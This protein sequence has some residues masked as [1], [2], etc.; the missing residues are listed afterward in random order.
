M[1]RVQLNESE[2]PDF[3]VIHFFRASSGE[4]RCR[5]INAQSRDSWIARDAADLR[6]RICARFTAPDKM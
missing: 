6:R 1:D 5:V 3:V 4:L 2:L